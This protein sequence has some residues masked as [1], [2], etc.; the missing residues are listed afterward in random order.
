MRLLIESNKKPWVVE[1]LY[2]FGQLT[3]CCCIRRRSEF[4]PRKRQKRQRQNEASH[5]EIGRMTE[6]LMVRK[7]AARRFYTKS[8][9]FPENIFPESGGETLFYKEALSIR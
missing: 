8:E 6:R 9:F 2:G 7:C 4:Q 3:G 1:S 5:R